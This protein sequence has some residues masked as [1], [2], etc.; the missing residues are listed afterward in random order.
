MTNIC[1]VGCG[2]WGR[3]ILHDLVALGARVYVVGRGEK[4]RAEGLAGGAAG[5]FVDTASLP[6]PVDGFVVATP[7]STHAAV[8]ETLLPFERPIF[9]EK[10]MSNDVGAARRLVKLAGGRIF[11]MDKWRYHP[12]IEALRDTARSG[13]LGRIEAVRTHRL[14]WGHPHRDVD[15]IWILMPHDLSIA[16]E[17]LGELPEAISAFAVAAGQGRWD[18][19]AVLGGAGGVPQVTAEVSTLHPARRRVVTVIG[20]DGSA[21]LDDS[22]SDHI[23]VAT[24]KPGGRP[25]EPTKVSVSAELPLLRELKAF[26]GH[27]GGGPPPRSSAAEGLLGVERITAIHRLAGL[28]L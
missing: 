8:I 12:G 21:A 4:S 27:I 15:A 23:L 18:I 28:T 10:P 1:L 16:Y 11:V 13:A 20:S 7:T 25:S 24:G 2:A 5:A 26:L 17:I 14:G 6:G 19:T 9:V 3:F 22:H